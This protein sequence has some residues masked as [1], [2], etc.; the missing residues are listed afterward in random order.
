MITSIMHDTSCIDLYNA[1]NWKKKNHTI[2]KF[3]VGSYK[4]R[5]NNIETPDKWYSL[6]IILANLGEYIWSR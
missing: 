3:F 5:N 6:Q 4:Q 2:Y 1:R